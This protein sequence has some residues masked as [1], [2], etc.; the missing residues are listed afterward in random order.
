MILK[1]CIR[2]ESG[3]LKDGFN[4]YPLTSKSSIGF[5]YRNGSKVTM[6]RYSKFLKKIVCQK[7]NIT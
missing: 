2:D 3:Q 1:A 7:P 6:Y 5:I 4:F